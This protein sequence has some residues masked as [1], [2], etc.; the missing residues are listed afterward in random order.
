[1]KPFRALGTW[2]KSAAVLAIAGVLVSIAG[3]VM[4]NEIMIR[5]GRALIAPCLFLTIM[6]IVVVIP[7]ILFLNRQQ[8][9]R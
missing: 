1:M 5:A 2:L 3:R 6:L 7:G 8:K 9:K 4:R